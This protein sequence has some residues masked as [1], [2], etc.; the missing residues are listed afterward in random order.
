MV[1]TEYNSTRLRGLDATLIAMYPNLPV[2]TIDNDV[3]VKKWF[4]FR[5]SNGVSTTILLN[6][7]SEAFNIPTT[8][9]QMCKK[10][11]Y[12]KNGFYCDIRKTLFTSTI[13]SGH[14]TEDSKLGFFIGA[15][16]SA[17]VSNSLTKSC[18][19]LKRSSIQREW[20][21]KGVVTVKFRKGLAFSN[22]FS[23]ELFLEKMSAESAYWE[24]PSYESSY[25]SK[26]VIYKVWADSI[27]KVVERIDEGNSQKLFVISGDAALDAI[28]L[29]YEKLNNN[30]KYS[31]AEISNKDITAD[32]YLVTESDLSDTYSV[33][34]ASEILTT[35]AAY[36]VFVS[37]AR[38]II[39][40]YPKIRVFLDV[41]QVLMQLASHDIRV[42]MP[43]LCPSC[44]EKGNRVTPSNIAL[45]FNLEAR[46]YLVQGDGCDLCVDGISSIH[47]LTESAFKDEKVY[48]SI[49][50]AQ[51]NKD[52]RLEPYILLKEFKKAEVS[53]IYTSL[54]AAL[55][56]GVVQLIDAKG[57]LI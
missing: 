50:E 12:V 38:N 46:E 5:K 2:F 44:S 13:L 9:S 11:T 34:R 18:L 36:V 51:N 47:V 27:H 56:H 10:G 40:L 31:C 43:K 53:S 22:Y 29:F 37:S 57:V 24:S 39:E 41:R 17:R 28:P 20:E 54:G 23:R 30:G 4:S 15:V 48:K 8:S 21:S 52:L 49:A 55:S 33:K 25:L 32:I 19:N 1:A 26:N 35:G 7:I 45:E 14:F 6:L 3:S 42:G 16:Y